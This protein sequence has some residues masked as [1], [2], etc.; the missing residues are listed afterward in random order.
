MLSTHS[1]P[2]N[3]HGVAGSKSENQNRWPL[4]RHNLHQNKGGFSKLLQ[5]F[6]DHIKVDCGVDCS[7]AYPMLLII[8]DFDDLVHFCSLGGVVSAMI[9][10]SLMLAGNLND[11]T[12]LQDYCSLVPK[13]NATHDPPSYD[14]YR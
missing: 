1:Q 14:I 11:N 5:K 2:K 13:R 9:E 4:P 3:K 10:V 7:N 6:V 12:A 8:E